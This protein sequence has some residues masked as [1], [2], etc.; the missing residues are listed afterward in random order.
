MNITLKQ[1]EVFYT[2]ARELNL[3]RAAKIMGMTP[4][5]VT[6]HVKNLEAICKVKLFGITGRQVYLTEAGLKLY[7]NIQPILT[8]STSLQGII[9]SLS[10]RDLQPVR[11]S[12]THTCQILYL[13]A[14][15]EFT[16]QNPDIKLQ[17]ESYTS[18]DNLQDSINTKPK[19]IYITGAVAD[20]SKVEYCQHQ[21]ADFKLILIAHKDNPICKSKSIEKG[22]TEQMCVGILS[23]SPAGQHQKQYWDKWADQKNFINVYSFGSALDVVRMNLGIAVVP[24]VLA[25]NDIQNG[26]FVE[27]KS[28]IEPIKFP[29]NI[30]HHRTRA[31]HEN[32]QKLIA[33]LEKYKI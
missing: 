25:K 7:S 23:S 33:F 10:E 20:L 31:L 22:I 8:E 26:T 21:S 14:I 2:A 18:L 11:L 32:A 16:E 27:L 13:P 4:P 3:A 9:G 5:A 6:K 19:D 29:I 30:F 24:D 28:S 17:L 12:L 1:L 15:K